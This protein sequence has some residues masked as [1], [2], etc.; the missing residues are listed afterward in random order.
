MAPNKI[1][2]QIREK[3]QEREIKPS[4]DA[5]GKLEARLGKEEKK[6]GVGRNTWFAIAAGFIGILILASV[7]LNSGNDGS[8]SIDVVS[9]EVNPEEI[10]S[11]MEN[12]NPEILTE[13]DQMKETLA[14]E[15]TVPMA[16]ER[17]DKVENNSTFIAKTEEAKEN[18]P[19]KTEKVISEVEVNEK[20]IAKVEKDPVIIKDQQV[21]DKDFVNSKVDEVVAQVENI[22]K[23]NN[24]VTPEEIDALLTSAQREISNRQILNSETKKV[25]AT[26]LLEDVEFELDAGGVNEVLLVGE[27][28]EGG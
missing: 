21:N 3:M 17:Q 28:K 23:T 25:D 7:F 2:D 6:R 5:W 16:I 1:E 10:N 27:E 19:E 14:V 4:A 9:E 18:V 8:N 15:Q 12:R 26:A 13:P 24:S 22:V 11:E 20:L